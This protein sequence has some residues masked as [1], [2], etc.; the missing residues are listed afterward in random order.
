[1]DNQLIYSDED[2]IKRFQDGDEQAYVELVNRYRD[3]LMNFVY[4]FTSDSEQSEDIVQETLIKL[5]THKH[6]Y[7]KIAKFSTWIYTIAANYAKTELRKK[8]N[9]KI[10]NLSQ[11]SSDEKDYDLPSVQPDADQLIESE[12]LEKRIQSAINT[13]PLH[14]KTVIVLRDIQELSYDEISNIVEVPL[15]TVKSRI[16]RARLQ[17]QK[18]LK[19]LKKENNF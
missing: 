10:T 17:L 6:Y 19:D 18:E 13:L 12:Y 8:K 1:M 7:K 16:N 2:L 4:R 3:R 15:G 5:Y 9:R 14:F 11:M